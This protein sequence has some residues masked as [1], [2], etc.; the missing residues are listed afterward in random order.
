MHGFELAPALCCQMKANKWHTSG[1][2]G[3]QGTE[4]WGNLRHGGLGYCTC[5][6]CTISNHLIA[7][8]IVPIASYICMGADWL[9]K[10]HAAWGSQ[11][12]TKYADCLTVVK[13]YHCGTYAQW[14]TLTASICQDLSNQ[15]QTARA[16]RHLCWL[17][18][19][20]A[21]RT[22]PSACCRYW[23]VE[24]FFQCWRV[25]DMPLRV[26]EYLF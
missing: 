25:C 7:L 12:I 3:I 26:Q 9:Q 20:I 17:L 16:A 10:P 6:S 19:P 4:G 22:L 2:W 23:F 21:W 13:W 14:Q 8:Q 18:C 24:L 15:D 5:G 1:Q 11:S